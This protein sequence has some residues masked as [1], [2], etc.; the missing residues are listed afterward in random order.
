MREIVIILIMAMNTFLIVSRPEVI[1][2]ENRNSVTRYLIKGVK[3]YV[4]EKGGVYVVH[5]KI[6]EFQP[7]FRN[8]ELKEA[9]ND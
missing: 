9:E 1:F 5:G 4:E 2:V 3:G 7:Y 8:F 6:R